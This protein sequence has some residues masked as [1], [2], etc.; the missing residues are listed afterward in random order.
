MFLYLTT[1]PTNATQ[2]DVGASSTGTDQPTKTFDTTQATYNG[3][4]G[5]TMPA[6]PTD[7]ASDPNTNV[8][9]EAPTTAGVG[10]VDDNIPPT[11]ESQAVKTNNGFNDPQPIT[12]QP[13]ILSKFASSTYNASVY[14]LTPTQY[15]TLIKSKQKKVNGYNLLFQT[16]GAPTNV[17]GAK[18]VLGTANAGTQSDLEAEG[19]GLA[20]N[21][22]TPGAKDPDAVFDQEHTG[23]APRNT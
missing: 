20:A 1:T 6:P 11:P 16:G 10:Q 8:G 21:V 17:G 4:S 18:G 15:E 13:N 9:K 3:V 12:P 23:Y 19:I 14:L 2:P 7:T 22:A 5:Q